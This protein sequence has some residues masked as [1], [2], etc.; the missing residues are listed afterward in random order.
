[1]YVTNPTCCWE[2]CDVEPDQCDHYKLEDMKY[3]EPNKNYIP[4]C[5]GDRVRILFINTGSFEISEGHP[6]HLH[7]HEFVLSELFNVTASNT[8]TINIL[9]TRVD[10]DDLN[11]EQ[12][13]FKR[14]GPKVCPFSKL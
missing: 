14:T 7:G 12:A 5:Y 13:E 11:Y 10:T 8:S 4:V 1:M 2:W 9:L 3:Y 6:M